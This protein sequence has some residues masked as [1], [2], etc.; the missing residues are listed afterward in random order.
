MVLYLQGRFSG[1]E[2]AKRRE[3]RRTVTPL[4]HNG[5]ADRNRVG[6]TAPRRTVDPA[7]SSLTVALR[8]H[9]QTDPGRSLAF[10]AP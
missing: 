10:F 8:L 1:S 3:A 6:R 2:Q 5:G 9:Q 4:L 7:Q